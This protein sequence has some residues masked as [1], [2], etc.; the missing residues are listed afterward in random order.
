MFEKN[1][2]NLN[3][4]PVRTGAKFDVLESSSVFPVLFCFRSSVLVNVYKKRNLK[5]YLF[6]TFNLINR[7]ALFRMKKISNLLWIPQMLL[8]ANSNNP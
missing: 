8:I 6:I 1:F 7:L 3:Q 4:G 5:K 2:K